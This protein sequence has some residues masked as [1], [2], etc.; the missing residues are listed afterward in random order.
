MA[1][2]L[3]QCVLEVLRISSASLALLVDGVGSGGGCWCR[4][5]VALLRDPD[6]N[7]TLS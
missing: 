1:S 4:V 3:A 5:V 2:S 7:W 6:L